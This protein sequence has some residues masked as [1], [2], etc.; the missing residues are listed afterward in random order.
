MN[1]EI[2]SIVIV[3]WI[4]KKKPL[5][6]CLAFSTSIHIQSSIFSSLFLLLFTLLVT[7]SFVGPISTTHLNGEEKK[8]LTHC[9]DCVE[10]LGLRWI[11]DILKRKA[12]QLLT[13]GVNM[14]F[15][16]G[17]TLNDLHLFY[18]LAKFLSRFSVKQL[19]LEKN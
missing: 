7:R 8:K 13:K 12:A 5:Q 2:Y 9:K 18:W 15:K 16:N 11:F 10:H 3:I 19:D 4:E 1:C 17:F 6:L 14:Y